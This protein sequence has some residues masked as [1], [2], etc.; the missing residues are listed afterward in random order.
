MILYLNILKLDYYDCLVSEPGLLPA[1]IILD[2]VLLQAPIALGAS[3]MSHYHQTCVA[4][5]ILL[6]AKSQGRLAAANGSERLG[7]VS[8][9]SVM[10]CI[11]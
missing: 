10:T 3:L 5:M 4:C 1:L 6:N 11:C 2:L 7:G 9:L 8:C